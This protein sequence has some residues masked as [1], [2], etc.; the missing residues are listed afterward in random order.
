LVD[1]AEQLVFP[2]R[3]LTGGKE[4]LD[5]AAGD[6]ARDGFKRTGP[7]KATAEEIIGSAGPSVGSGPHGSPAKDKET[8]DREL[9]NDG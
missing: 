4:D 8:Y 6:F 3:K 5:F 7:G 9:L 2:N 1:P